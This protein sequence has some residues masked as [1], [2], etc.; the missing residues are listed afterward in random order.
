MAKWVIYFDQR[1]WEYE[2][3][4]EIKTT[5]TGFRS[6]TKNWKLMKSKS[7]PATLRNVFLEA[8]QW[9]MSLVKVPTLTDWLHSIAPW[10]KFPLAT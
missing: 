9:T 6:E 1:S 10:E 5:G 7:I 4:T 2:S 8:I 3:R